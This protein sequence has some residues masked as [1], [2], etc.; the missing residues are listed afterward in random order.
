MLETPTG[1]LLLLVLGGFAGTLAGLLGIGG[2]LLMVPASDVWRASGTSYGDQFSRSIPEFGFGKYPQFEDEGAELA[3][4]VGVGGVWYFYG[5][6]GSL[7]GR[8]HSRPLAL[9]VICWTSAAYHLLNEFAAI[10]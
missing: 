2:G 4:I 9:S 3:D 5:T 6:R 1:W 7:V 8:S 10:P